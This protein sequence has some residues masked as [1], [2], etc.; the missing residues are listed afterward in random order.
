LVGA[1]LATGMAACSTGSD[2]PV[3]SSSTDDIIGGFPAT[4]AKLNAVG[5]LGLANGNGG[6]TPFCSGTLISSNMVVA[7]RSW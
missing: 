1:L 2:E 6:F 5:A 4:S 3:V 7:G